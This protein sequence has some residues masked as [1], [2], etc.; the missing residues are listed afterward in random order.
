MEAE[1]DTLG[2]TTLG[3]TSGRT[4]ATRE[5]DIPPQIGRYTVLKAIGAGG[6]GV[7]YAAYDTDLDRKLAIK[8]L[9]HGVAEVGPGTVGHSRL[10]REA[11][12]MAKISHPNVLQVFEVG[13]HHGQVFLALEFVEGTTLEGWLTAK[14]RTWREVLAVFIQAGR[15]LEAA[16]AVGLVH[17]DFKPENVLVDLQDRVRVMDFGLARAAGTSDPDAPLAPRST[18]ST[19]ALNTHLTVTGAIMGTPLYMAPEQ[20]VGGLADARADEF[21]FCVALYEALYGQRPF[22]GDDIKTLALNVLQGLVREP[23]RHK[24]LPT[25]LRKAILRGLSPEPDDRY[26]SMTALL[27]ELARDRAAIRR[28][29]ALAATAAASLSVGVWSVV[30]ASAD[31]CSGAELQLADVW[32]EA[33]QDSVAAALRATGRPYADRTWSKVQTHLG[34]YTRAWSEL[35]VTACE[36]HARGESSDDLYDLTMVCLARRHSELGALV[37]RL[38]RAD[39]EVLDRAVS[40]VRSLTPVAVCADREALLARVRPPE[41][42]ALR[43]AVDLRRAELDQAKAAQDAGKFADGLALATVT[44]AAADGIGHRPLIAEARLRLGELHSRTSEYASAEAALM[45]ALWA[46]E[47][48]RHDEIAAAT[49]TELIRLGVRQGKF[50]DAERAAERAGAAVAR[51]GA[52]IVAEARLD[53]EL[54]SMAFHTDKGPEAV[55][56]YERALALRERV[57]GSD[58]PDT[59]ATLANLG[60]A[61]LK[62]DRVDEAI[63]ATTRALT[64]REE[65]LGPDHPDVATTLNNLGVIYR[66][67]K[68]T[69]EALAAYDRAIKI[70]KAAFGPDNPTVINALLNLANIHLDRGEP[71]KGLPLLEEAVA[72]AKRTL[73]DDNPLR[74]TAINNLG[75]FFSHV[76]QNDRAAE[77]LRESLAIRERVFGADS[78]KLAESLSNLAALA[79]Q[80]EREDEALALLERALTLLERSAGSEHSGLIP[81]L[82]NLAIIALGRG[83]LDVAETH[84]RHAR[85]ILDKVGGEHRSGVAVLVLEGQL[86]LERNHAA[87]ALALL[88]QAHATARDESQLESLAR[89]DLDFALARALVLTGGDR[90]RARTLA[91]A[92]HAVFMTHEMPR[93]AGRIEAWLTRH[94]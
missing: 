34:D 30:H 51:L 16:H 19:S 9:H 77:L 35:H 72:I 32:D 62:A 36:T 4:V 17:R 79:L 50:A 73:P 44:A 68:R 12:A 53:N 20:H 23:P 66:T 83:Q 40:A 89:A 1:S 49:W 71:M 38:A 54:G 75:G 92:A 85:R 60:N 76:G 26:A 2:G 41:D 91:E 90:T 25:W 13:V 86:A 57:L 21:A 8:L 37:D 15:G 84:I 61:L 78:P 56:R 22:L 65:V 67:V 45:A 3:A 39:G 48:G 7:V 55:T 6:M 47:A 93:H 69:D 94:R 82:A 31:Q 24:K 46:A 52:D 43:A 5:G 11:Q 80:R 14:P 58:H 74:L 18:S 88:E 59:L 42:P 10:L 63:A 27:A 87:P 28:R 81:P 33:H 29:W 70:W 64:T